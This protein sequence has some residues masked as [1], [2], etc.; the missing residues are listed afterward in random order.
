MQ[1][2]LEDFF[3]LFI[4]APLNSSDPQEFLHFNTHVRRS[5]A[6]AFQI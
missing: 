4:P 1:G 3:F 2:L 5:G 6:H